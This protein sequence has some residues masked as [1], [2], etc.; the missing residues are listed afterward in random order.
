M[1]DKNS[2][3]IKV[4]DLVK[5]YGDVTAVN[6]I[7]FTI[8]EGD[9]FAFLGPN[10]AGKSTAIKILTTVLQPTSGRIKV[11]GYD[12]AV[13][14]EKH[15]IRKAI[16]VIFQDHT[17]DNELTA[18][19]NL[20]YHSVLYKVPKE[21]RKERIETMLNNIGLWK[22][23]NNIIKTFSGG[24]KR[25]VEIIRGLLHY[26]KILI[27]DEPTS[28]LDAQTRYFLWNHIQKINQEDKITIFLT[29]HN[30]EEAEKVARNIAIIDNGQI[31]ASGNLEQIKEKANT[32]SLEKAFLEITGYALR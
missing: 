10:G 11:D 25:R 29:T 5:K 24:M 14:K 7:S 19:E 17:L 8:D 22:S 13:E 21:E 1:S 23:R 12:A 30:L 16:G 15:K 2:K 26:P 28:G 27:L 9:I 6:N 20:Y 18:Y 3:I 4:E 31:L 32:A